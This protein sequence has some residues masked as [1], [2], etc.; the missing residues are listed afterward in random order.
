ME[1]GSI[2]DKKHLKNVLVVVMISILFGL[3]YGC[4]SKK[5]GMDVTIVNN[6][7]DRISGIYISYKHAEKDI[8]I[9]NIESKKSYKINIVPKEEF[10]ESSM[11]IY[12]KD[13]SGIL[14][15]EIIVPYFEKKL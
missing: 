15:S 2:L 12:Y 14:H 9:P 3:L 13:K 8:S 1:E 11:S 5:I 6:T 4:S 10:A 7:K